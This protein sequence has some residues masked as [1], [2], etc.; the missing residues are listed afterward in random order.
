MADRTT[1]IRLEV[2]ADEVG[3]LDGYCQAT[4][5]TRTAVLRSLLQEWSDRK[6]HEAKVILRVAGGHPA[7]PEVA[8]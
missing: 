3:V 8:R 7:S 5:K 2:P 1:E 6:H 4:G